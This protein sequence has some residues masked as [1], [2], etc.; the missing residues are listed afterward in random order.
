MYA[1]EDAYFTFL[2]KE[3]LEA[4]LSVRCDESLANLPCFRMT[5]VRVFIDDQCWQALPSVENDDDS[6]AVEG[7]LASCL[8]EIPSQTEA[9]LHGSR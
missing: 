5:R 9:T 4:M 7:Q 6:I 8:E 2:L 1:A 3:K